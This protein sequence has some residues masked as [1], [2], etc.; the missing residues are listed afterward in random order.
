MVVGAG[1]DC[2]VIDAGVP[3]R[4][5]LHKTDPGSRAFILRKTLIRSRL[6]IRPLA[7]R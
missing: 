6:A 1:D 5:Q 3:G 4:W 2:A 7:A